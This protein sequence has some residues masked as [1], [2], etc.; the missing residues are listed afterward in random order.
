MLWFG[1]HGREVH[2]LWGSRSWYEYRKEGKGTYP[3]VIDDMKGDNWSFSLAIKNEYLGLAAAYEGLLSIRQPSMYHRRYVCRNLMT[4]APFPAAFTAWNHTYMSLCTWHGK[5]MLFSSFDAE[6][7]VMEQQR[8]Q[9]RCG[10][11]SASPMEIRQA[12]CCCRVN[13]RS[14]LE[15]WRSPV[16]WTGKDNPHLA[17]R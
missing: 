2:T 11:S 10:R 13:Y 17:S 16:A 3:I 5:Q 1:F 8:Q 9:Q 15:G 6:G 14:S 4:T 12:P 7:L